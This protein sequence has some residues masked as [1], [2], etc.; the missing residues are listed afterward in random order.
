MG[1][2]TRLSTNNKNI[3]ENIRYCKKRSYKDFDEKSFLE[4]VDKISWWEVYSC[5]DVD[6]ALDIFT[7]KL[8]DILDRMAP[9]KKF[10]IRVKYAAWVCKETK[11]MML[12]RDQAQQTA[13]RSGLD[14]DWDTYRRLRNQVTSQ[15]RKDKMVWQK[16]NLESCEENCDTGRMW[17]NILGWL[18]WT[19]TSSPTKLLSQGNIETSPSRLADIQNKYYIEKVRTIRRGLQGQD[20]DPLQ[21]LRNTLQG[22]QASFTTKAVTPEQ[23][24]K[25]I[26]DLKNSKASGVDNLDTYILK[27]VRKKIVPSVC[28]ILNLSIQSNKFPTKWKIAK[29][30]PLYK[31]KGSKLE[32]KNYRPVAILPILSKVLERAMFHQLVYYIDANKFFNPNHH[33]TDPSTPQQLLCSRCTPPGLRPYS[34]ETWLVSA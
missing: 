17:K 15:L 29:V 33:A 12:D 23:V 34:K 24:D 20:R 3:K 14:S 11:S 1:Y 4:E 26:R 27:L 13:S 9:V 19:S 32:P 10:Q 8:T 25:I 28:H 18:N 30:V 22:N 31:G 5:E 7:K 21:V 16:E 6:M 2:N